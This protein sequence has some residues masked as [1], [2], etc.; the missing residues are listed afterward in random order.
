[1]TLDEAVTAANAAN[2]DV[3]VLIAESAFGPERFAVMA[4]TR[5]PDGQKYAAWDTYESPENLV[6]RIVDMARAEAAGHPV[7]AGTAG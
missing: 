4:E 2:P 1:M 5:A 6:A 3:T 7:D